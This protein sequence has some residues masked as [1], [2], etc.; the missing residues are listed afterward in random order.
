[1]DV[2]RGRFKWGC[3]VSRS[4]FLLR[5]IFGEYGRDKAVTLARDGLDECRTLWNIAERRASFV[6]RG[7]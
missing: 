4:A 6:E 2:F 5:A 1:M 3:S 7:V